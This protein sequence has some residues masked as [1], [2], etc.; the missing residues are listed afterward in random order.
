MTGTLR[1]RILLTVDG[2]V[3]ALN[4]V[5]YVSGMM[6]KDHTDIVLFNVG[7]GFPEVFY[8][9]YHLYATYF[10]LFALELWQQRCGDGS[11]AAMTDGP[12]PVE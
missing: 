4:V 11:D 6:S 1:R 10:P 9:K 2:S 7:T 5:R 12:R 3:Q 8:L